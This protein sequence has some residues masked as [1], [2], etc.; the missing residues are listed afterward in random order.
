MY[1]EIAGVRTASGV[2]FLK[3]CLMR[4][5]LICTGITESLEPFKA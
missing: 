1:R 5:A 2:N 4:I 3:L